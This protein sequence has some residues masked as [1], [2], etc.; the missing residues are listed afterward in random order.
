MILFPR[1][2]LPAGCLSSLRLFLKFSVF[3]SWRPAVLQPGPLLPGQMMHQL[4]A[5][6]KIINKT[7]T[8]TKTTSH[9]MF[10]LFDTSPFLTPHSLSCPSHC[11]DRQRRTSLIQICYSK[12][13]SQNLESMNFL[14]MFFFS[15]LL[16]PRIQ[17]SPILCSRI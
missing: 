15:C 13:H 10:G 14:F 11:L 1:P 17:I 6:R 16:S 5:K 9:Q 8:K 3:L 7:T 12:E 4:S 2:D